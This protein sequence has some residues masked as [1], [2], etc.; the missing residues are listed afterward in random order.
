MGKGYYEDQQQFDNTMKMLA[1]IFDEIEKVIKGLGD[2]IKAREQFAPQRQM[3]E[4]I[5]K[6]GSF[7]LYEVQGK[8]DAE[9]A[10]ELQQKGIPHMVSLDTSKIL[11]RQ[12]DH[13]FVKAL[14]ERALIAKG[15]YYQEV[16]SSRLETAIAKTDKIRDKEI[17][18]LHGL[19]KYQYEVL[20]NKCN[21]ITKGFMVG[22][23]DEADGKIA[24]S[25]HAQKTIVKDPD[26]TDFCK[27]FA[28]SMLS[29]HGANAEVKCRQIDADERLD[30][31]VAELKGC[32]A[33]H[34]V[35]G[36]DDPTRYIEINSQGFEFH[37]IK[38]DGTNTKNMQEVFVSKDRPDYE[39]ELQKY[40][41]SI[42][43]KTIV[44]DEGKLFEHATN[45]K[46]NFETDR[47]EKDE[48]QQKVSEMEKS[49]VDRANFMVKT[50]PQ[51]EKLFNLP[52]KEA[53]ILY[54]NEMVDVIDAAIK[55]ETLPGYFEEDFKSI[56][57]E[58]DKVGVEP[59]DYQLAIRGFRRY[60]IENHEAK[61]R[62]T[63]ALKKE[64]TVQFKENKNI[65]ADERERA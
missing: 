31:Q 32:E 57:D 5:K 39:I 65:D 6:G 42:Y 27:A 60:D 3:G 10:R 64:K 56:R 26:K 58:F 50:G 54:Q 17:L 28:E 2:Q 44:D 4:W 63:P 36:V 19:D 1:A 62:K 11:I 52:P 20:K 9:L 37:R 48:L 29:L 33:S 8:C 23:E 14:N 59:Q 46:R 61:E 25:I 49:V 38:T 30:K 47:P 24:L 34:F 55:G 43:N 40:M 18:T 13:D 22:F 7:E 15:N 45:W 51:S 21:N 12:K 16:E 35:I 53:F 41:D